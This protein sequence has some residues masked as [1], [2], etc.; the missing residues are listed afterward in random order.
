L[1]A[2]VVR[3]AE[4]FF[5]APVDPS[6]QPSDPVVTPGFTVPDMLARLS[7]APGLRQPE[8]A[9]LAALLNPGASEEDRTAL[10]PRAADLPIRAAAP[11]DPVSM[12]V[13]FTADPIPGDPT[14]ILSLSVNPRPLREILSVP[15]VSQI[16]RLPE[17][18]AATGTAL[19]GG[20]GGESA[21]GRGAGAS[22]PGGSGG[23][24]QGAAGPDAVRISDSGNWPSPAAASLTHG[25]GPENGEA[26]PLAVERDRL[27][28]L[29]EPTRIVHPGN[30][31]F[32]VVVQSSAL[33]G[34]PESPGILTGRPIYSVYLN[35]G[36]RREWILQYAIPGRDPYGAQHNWAVVRLESTSPL[37]PP[38]PRVTLLPP[39]RKRPASSYVMIHGF[40]NGSGRFED[41]K[42]IGPA[43]AEERP[44]IA[45]VLGEWEFRPASQDGA[46]VRVEVLL[47][48]PSE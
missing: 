30:G 7:R 13:S 5:W 26:G 27:L 6:R 2:G 32:D 17:A 31:V 10:V 14:A 25:S 37:S 19:R 12:A 29:A 42:V 21:D 43:G 33:D 44:A 46:P 35:V 40:L 24:H 4:F 22:S 45:A 20:K 9:A 3:L 16:G 15:P 18:T 41:L 48:I 34:I 39:L 38:Y 36:T 11:E 28:A 8:I 47:A 23:P 1:P